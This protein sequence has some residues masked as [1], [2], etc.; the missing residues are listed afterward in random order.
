MAA[1]AKGNVKPA[2]RLHVADCPQLKMPLFPRD[3]HCIALARSGNPPVT[4]TIKW[5]ATLNRMTTAHSETN[6]RNR[7]GIIE[8]LTMLH[9]VQAVAE[10]VGNVNI[11]QAI[12]DLPALFARSNQPHL[13]QAAQVVRQGRYAEADCLGQ[14]ADI[15][16]AGSQ[17]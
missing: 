13:A 6:Q 15:H 8:G 12:E 14:R 9:V 3:V 5:V 2:R 1:A 16:L 11:F 4:W 17:R 10:Q 7:K